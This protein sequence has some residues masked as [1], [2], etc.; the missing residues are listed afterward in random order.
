M[1]YTVRINKKNGKKII[2][3]YQNKSPRVDELIGVAEKEFP[4]IPLSQLIV[5]TGLI[6]WDEPDIVTLTTK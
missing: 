6:E 3:F 2:D 1:D 4:S 5:G